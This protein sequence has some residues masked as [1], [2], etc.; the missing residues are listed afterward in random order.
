M[1]D[2]GVTRRQPMRYEQ[3]AG[4]VEAM[5]LETDKDLGDAAVWLANCGVPASTGRPT[6][7]HDRKVTFS[8]PNGIESAVVGTVLVRCSRE[9]FTVIDAV[10]FR[11]R[12]IVV[13]P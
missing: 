12:Y 10:E 1:T 3:R 5:P 13:G 2:L 8:T 9:V 4:E 7:T 6:R 11:N